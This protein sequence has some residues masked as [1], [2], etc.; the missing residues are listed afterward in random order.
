MLAEVADDLAPGGGHGHRCRG[1]GSAQIGIGVGAKVGEEVDVI[2]N[3][4]DGGTP[5]ALHRGGCVD[6]LIR[7]GE[8]GRAGETV[9]GDEVVPADD[10]E[11]C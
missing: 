6:R 10:T 3:F 8:S 11:E 2:E 9:V 1:L 7:E 5:T 4:G